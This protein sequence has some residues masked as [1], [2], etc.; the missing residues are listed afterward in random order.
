MEMKYAETTTAKRIEENYKDITEK[1]GKGNYTEGVELKGQGKTNKPLKSQ[2]TNTDCLWFKSQIIREYE[3]TVNVTDSE[4]RKKT[5]IRRGSETVSTTE[6]SIVFDLDD[7]SGATIKIN[8]EGSEIVGKQ[9]YNQFKPGE[10]TGPLNF[11]L[12]ALAG[13]RRTI[14]Y[15]YI[16]QII[17]SDQRLYIL[18]EASDKNGVLEVKNFSDKKK[19]FIISINRKKN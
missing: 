7:G 18:G 3:E 8:P 16:E 11:T 15:R 9:I 4:G 19:K 6:D 13:G 2:H 10:Y 1:L 12:N 5:E 17:P 14:G